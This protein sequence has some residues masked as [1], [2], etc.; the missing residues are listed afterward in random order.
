MLD[1]HLN[2]RVAS[3]IVITHSVLLAWFLNTGLQRRD[4]ETPVELAITAEIIDEGRGR[5]A[6]LIPE[7]TLARPRLALNT[8]TLI[9][10]ESA[11]WG[12]VSGVLAPASAPQLSRFQRVNPATFAHRAGLAA[13]QPASIVLTIEVLPDGT[14]G[15]IE[16][17]RAYD[18]PA[19]DAA[20]IAYARQLRWIPGTK[21]RHAESMRV[22]LPVT[23]VW[24]T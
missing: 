24:T 16:V 14:A 20:A 3:A 21:N 22:N 18:D 1:L 4:L 8:I 9:R 13:G 6:V 5:D 12:D 19:V 11:D 10:F 17:A 23:L 7:V 15:A 2:W